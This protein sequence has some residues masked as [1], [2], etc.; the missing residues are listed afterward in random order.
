[1]DR[2]AAAESKLKEASCGSH[3]STVRTDAR[4]K[5]WEQ[6][7]RDMTDLASRLVDTKRK[8]QSSERKREKLQL[9]HQDVLSAAV[10]KLDRVKKKYKAAKLPCVVCAR[11]DARVGQAL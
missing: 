10:G 11:R 2:A 8:L 4:T 9:A 3:L 1:M 6:R 7:T 5:Y